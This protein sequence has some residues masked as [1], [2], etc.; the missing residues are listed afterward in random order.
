MTRRVL[1]TCPQLQDSIDR[2]RHI[3][4]ENDIELEMPELVQQL[5][6]PQLLEIIDRFHGV[7]AG[8]DEF[9]ASVL[10]K[11][12]RLKVISRWGVGVD[13]IDLAAASE[14]GIT[15]VNT[16][17]VFSDEV[18][19]VV[20]GYIILLARQLHRLDR[21]VRSGQWPKI[22]GL[23]LRGKTLGVIGVGN[24][25][26]AVARRAV[27]CGMNVVGYD[28]TPIPSQV[29]DDTGLN[30]V[31]FDQLI[32][33]SD[34][35]TLNCNLTPENRHMLSHREFGLMKPGIYII[36]A[37]RGPLIDEAALVQA[38]QDGTVLGAA[39]DVFEDEPLTSDNPLR[40]FDNCIFGTHNSSNTRE[41]VM[42][43]NDLAIQNLLSGLG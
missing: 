12:S 40:Q 9:T 13:A 2:Y 23:S 18:A 4:D 28:V 10:A 24:I 39:L 38:L 17:A 6:E 16:P 30:Q 43:V 25:G 15:V 7:I 37:S 36:N 11:A 19:D 26:S 35:I 1:V 20:I 14:H 33:T 32:Q 41:A 42:R 31:S 21:D 22:Q 3:F 27:A 34:F 29:R 5:S 8:D